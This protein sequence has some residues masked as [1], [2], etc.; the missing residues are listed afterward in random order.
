A[1]VVVD[2]LEVGADRG[3]DAQLVV[4]GGGQCPVEMIEQIVL[5]LVQQ[6]EVELQLAREVLI[7]HRFAD[8]GPH[9]DLVHRG[10]MKALSHEDLTRGPQQLGTALITGQAYSAGGYVGRG[11]HSSPHGCVTGSYRCRPAA[12]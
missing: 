2:E 10:G 7:E 11:S 8:A 1:G 3:L 6:R 5:R 9:R 4:V 12:S